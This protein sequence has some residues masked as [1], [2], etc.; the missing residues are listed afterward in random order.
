[1]DAALT[2]E[3]ER[4]FGEAAVRRMR[5]PGDADDDAGGRAPDET[6][7]AIEGEADVSTLVTGAPSLPRLRLS[8]RQQRRLWHHVM[9][10]EDFWQSLAEIES[11]AVARLARLSAER[12]W[13]IIFVTKRPH[14][15]GA[16]A[17][18][19]SQRWLESRGFPLP[20][21]YVVRASRGLIASA[22][23][24][25]VVVDDRPENC[26]DVVTDSRAKPI[27]VWRESEK[28]LPAA[29][30]RLGVTIVPSVD[31]CLTLLGEVDSDSS[32]GMSILARFKQLLGIKQRANA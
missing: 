12:R 9:S 21:V 17:Q 1:M 11:G 23:S 16:T 4:V 20:S 5:E 18:L 31:A 2:R 7:D 25:D 8:A 3:A 14:T 15:A 24:L 26:F 32:A 10:I 29:A 13:E 28:L 6:S 22:L 19:Q 30:H 27:L